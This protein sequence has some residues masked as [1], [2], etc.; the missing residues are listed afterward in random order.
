MRSREEYVFMVGGY[1][2]Y[3]LQ[4]IVGKPLSAFVREVIEDIVGMIHL[5]EL[6]PNHHRGCHR[7]RH[8]SNSRGNIL[9]PERFP[10][11]FIVL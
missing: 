6:Y 4:F 5:V 2:F 10:F 1:A 7:Y 11:G 3:L 8:L 9:P